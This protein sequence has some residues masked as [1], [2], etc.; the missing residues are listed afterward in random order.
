MKNIIASELYKIRKSKLIY[1]LFGI[2]L[3]LVLVSAA[4]MVFLNSAGL[5]E[6]MGVAKELSGLTGLST[7]LADST[8]F[9]V[10]AIFVSITTLNDFNSGCIRQ[11]ISKGTSRTKYIVGK[12]FAMSIVGILLMLFNMVCYFTAYSIIGGKTGLAGMDSE[13]LRHLLLMLAGTVTFVLSYTAIIEFVSVLL[14]KTSSA[15]VV[16]ILLSTIVGS[17]I[18]I[19]SIFMENATLLNYWLTTMLINF[20]D[21]TVPVSTK[22]IYLAV[23][24]GSAVV[25]TI[26][27]A[28]VFNKRDIA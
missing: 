21:F 27:N 16:S 8:I 7:C 17:T 12:Y 5:P 28:L 10:L 14:R 18:Q 2:V 13:L 6:E 15:L 19:L 11:I 9:L 26:G 4:L 23:M 25:F 24:G 22:L 3:I 1:I 20:G